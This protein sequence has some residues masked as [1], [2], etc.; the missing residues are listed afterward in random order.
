MGTVI[1]LCIVAGIIVWQVVDWDKDDKKEEPYRLE[2]S[3]SELGIY[4]QAAVSSDSPLC[5]DIAR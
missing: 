4:K 1:V 3:E 5:S 2:P